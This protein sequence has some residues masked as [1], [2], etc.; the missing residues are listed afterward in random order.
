[1]VGRDGFPVQ[2]HPTRSTVNTEDLVVAYSFHGGSL[3]VI[4]FSSKGHTFEGVRE[5]LLAYRG[6]CQ[7]ALDDFEQLRV[8]RLDRKWRYRSFYRDHGHQA[9]L[10]AAFENSIKRGPYDHRRQR[11]YVANTAMLFL[12]TKEA[13]DRNV[14]VMAN[15]YQEESGGRRAA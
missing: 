15:G 8:E 10:L 2:I 14:P 4:S 5:R 11:E 3:G 13:V 12:K 6:E 9:S 7:V 1:M